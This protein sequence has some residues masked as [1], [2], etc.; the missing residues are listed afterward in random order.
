VYSKIDV[1]ETKML[2]LNTK[3][4]WLM[5]AFIL[6]NASKWLSALR[7]QLFFSSVKLN[8]NSLYNLK[9]YYIGMFYNLFLP[10]A[11]GGDGYKVY[12]LSKKYQTNIRLLI[13]ASLIDRISGMVALLFLAG[14][15]LSMNT[16]NLKERYLVTG[17]IACIFFSFP[18]YYV[19]NR[20]L[21]KT[22]LPAFWQT[23]RYSIGVQLFQLAS[24]SCILLSLSTES[25]LFNYLTLF[26]ISSVVA[27]LPLTIGG[28][29]AREM[30][31]IAGAEFMLI[32]TPTAISFS[33]MFFLIT[34]VS[35]FIGVFLSS[36]D[37]FSSHT[38][39]V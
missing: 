8:L 6:F 26:L 12:L 28:I 27:I 1:D 36:H 10:G 34:A 29:G 13:N 4:E 25:H 9:L 20:T 23:S 19:L 39:L 5:F 15:L 24:A 32:D 31:F 17:I 16:N 38:K 14:I 37:S 35:S 2:L 18:G 7:L 11:I 30:V 22:F 3:W 21:F 33:L